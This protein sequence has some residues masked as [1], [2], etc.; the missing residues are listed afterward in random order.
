MPISAE[1][2][3]VALLKNASILHVSWSFIYILIN[4][5]SNTEEDSKLMQHVIEW[6]CLLQE[7]SNCSC[8]DCGYGNLLLG[9]FTLWI[10]TS[11]KDRKRYHFLITEVLQVCNPHINYSHPYIPSFLSLNNLFFF[12]FCWGSIVEEEMTLCVSPFAL[13]IYVLTMFLWYWGRN[14]LKS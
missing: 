6:F 13:P 10:R 1:A 14:L 12:F 2:V 9:A 7:L 8:D 5:C 3:S 4:H 11:L